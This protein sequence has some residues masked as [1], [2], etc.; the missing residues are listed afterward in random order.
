MPHG[1]K[2][3]LGDTSKPEHRVLRLGN[4]HFDATDA[5]LRA[6][7]EGFNVL[8]WKRDINV[9]SGKTTIAYVLMSSMQEVFRAE[10]ELDNKELLE[11]SVRILRAKAGFTI[12]K[13]GLLNDPEPRDNAEDELEAGTEDA[14]EL[15]PEH[16]GSVVEPVD[17]DSPSLNIAKYK[18][19]KNL[20]APS[21]VT[22]PHRHR[23]M[24]TPSTEPSNRVLFISN[25]HY[26]ANLVSINLFFNGYKVTDFKPRRHPRTNKALGFGFV[27]LGSLEE[28]NRAMRELQG[29]SLMGKPVRLEIANKGVKVNENG[30]VDGGSETLPARAERWGEDDRG[31]QPLIQFKEVKWTKGDSDDTMPTKI[32]LAKQAENGR[33]TVSPFDVGIGKPGQRQDERAAE[34]GNTASPDRSVSLV[35]ADWAMRDAPGSF[36][37]PNIWSGLNATAIGHSLSTWDINLA[38]Q[39]LRPWNLAGNNSW[40]REANMV[41]EEDWYYFQPKEASKYN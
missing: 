31:I 41:T 2:V 28:R 11:R 22:T 18:S 35:D 26:A 3:A 15:Q 38:H 13:E 10:R 21:P 20:Y 40:D 14:P 17:E 39:V 5:D 32:A 16:E 29:K 37:S 7:F 36:W 4:L 33:S 9:N 12:T 8:D 34:T 30:F 6:F 19:G 27:M 23:K 24:I 1:T 25:L